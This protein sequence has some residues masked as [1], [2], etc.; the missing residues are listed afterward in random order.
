MQDNDTN[1]IRSTVRQLVLLAMDGDLDVMAS[2]WACF[3]QSNARENGDPNQGSLE[4]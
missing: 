3:L 4:M 2:L 1:V